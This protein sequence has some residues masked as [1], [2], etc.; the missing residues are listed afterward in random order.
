MQGKYS[1][2]ELMW[3][4]KEHTSLENTSKHIQFRNNSYR[5]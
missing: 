1:N 2:Y 4:S 5:L 3:F